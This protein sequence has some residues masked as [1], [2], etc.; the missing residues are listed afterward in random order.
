MDVQGT[1]SSRYLSP[2]WVFLLFLTLITPAAVP[3][4]HGTT[5]GKIPGSAS[6]SPE[7]AQVAY[8]AAPRHDV[9]EELGKIL[10]YESVIPFIVILL[11]IAL[12]PLIRE[13]WWESNLHKGV[14]S[15]L[16]SLPIFVYLVWIS[17]LGGKALVENLHEY[18]A[19]I[20]L[21]VALFTISGGIHLEGDLKA[22]PLINTIFLGTGALLAS[23]ISTTGA[24]MLLIRPLL[25]T[26][27]ERKKKSHVFIF[28]IFLVANIGGSLL[29]IGDPPLFLGYLSGVPFFWTLRLW[30]IWLTEVALLLAIFYIW[31]NFAYTRE[32][33]E[34]LRRDI[35][36]QTQLKI[37]GKINF[38]LILGVLGSVVFFKPHLVNGFTIDLSWMQQPALIFLALI[39]FG[40]DYRSKQKAHKMGLVQFK[41]PRENNW[42]TFSPMAEVGILF[43]GIFIT[44]TPAICLLRA[45]GAAT[46]IMSSWQF[47]WISGVLSSFL[48]NA[49]TYATFFALGQSVT[50]G[51]L[52]T[53]P[54][55]PVVFTWNGPILEQILLAISVGC[56][57]MGANTYIGN[58]PNFMVKAICEEGK[59]KMPGFFSYMLYSCVILLPSFFLIMFIYM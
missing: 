25:K 58:A 36:R 47:F 56:V 54:H 51:I 19:F 27:S 29:P 30:P 59:V 39:S 50:E 34:D 2:F 18:Y 28:F 46:G 24:A 35:V 32:R 57:F 5:G 53:A 49:P 14:V 8:A 12:I 21:L 4:A 13:G 43:M 38:L 16:C 22:T 10:P 9:Q 15:L 31:D 37:H 11:A 6:K 33:K 26:N 20:T 40:I 17:P 42:F 1:M 48:D 55:L 23:F 3:L 45:H 7:A 41:T 52:A 44:M